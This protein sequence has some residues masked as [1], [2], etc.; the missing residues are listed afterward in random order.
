MVKKQQ[1]AGPIDVFFVHVQCLNRK[2]KKTNINL[3]K[4]IA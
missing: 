2:E 3:I 4:L 1:A